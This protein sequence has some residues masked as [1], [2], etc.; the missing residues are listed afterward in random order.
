MKF[1]VSTFPLL[2]LIVFGLKMAAGAKL[3]EGFNASFKVS[4]N[5]AEE[6][7]AAAFAHTQDSQFKNPNAESNRRYSWDPQPSAALKALGLDFAPDNVILYVAEKSMFYAKGNPDWL[8]ALE[9]IHQKNGIA[10]QCLE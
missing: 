9:E 4:K 3:P 8:H 7:F 2:I 10:F 5:Y 1:S 6:L